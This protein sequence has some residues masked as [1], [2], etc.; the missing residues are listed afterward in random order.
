MEQETNYQENILA[1]LAEIVQKN[2]RAYP[3]DFDLDAKKLWD[4]AQDPNME[5]RAFYWMSRPHGT[6]CVREREVFLDDTNANCIW[7][8]YAAYP[9]GILAYRIVVEGI[10]DGKL[11]GK[12]IPI[13]YA[14]QVRRVMRSV[15]P[16]ATIQYRDKN[17][18]FC[19][20]SYSAFM[21]STLPFEDGIHD[22]RYVPESEAELQRIIALEHRMES[23]DKRLHRAKRLTSQR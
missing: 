8:H 20:D 12:V 17:E 10:R 14:K 7:T 15:L 1:F 23:Q 3:E 4:S 6:W 9:D 19:E 21:N 5:N 13:D 2:T 16:V 18:H 11:A 22:I